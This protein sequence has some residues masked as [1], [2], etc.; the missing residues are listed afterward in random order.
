M[1]SINSINNLLLYE[2]RDNCARTI[3]SKY[4]A[5]ISNCAKVKIDINDYKLRLDTLE[6]FLLDSLGNTQKYKLF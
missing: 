5:N 1:V 2:L 3:E 4:Y 6:I